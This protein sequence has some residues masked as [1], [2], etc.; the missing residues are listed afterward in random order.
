MVKLHPVAAMTPARLQAEPDL[1]AALS[2]T[3]ADMIDLWKRM[4]AIFPGTVLDKEDDPE[5]FFKAKTGENH[6]ITLNQTKEYETK[7]K[8]RLTA[9][10]QSHP[11]LYEKL[12]MAQLPPP[13]EAKKDVSDILY[14]VVK[15]LKDSDLLPAVA[16]QLDTY[17]AFS[18]FKTLLS[19]LE[20]EQVAEF[21]DY[22]KDLMKL[23]RDKAQMRKVAAGQ[24][25][26]VNAAEAEE[27]AKSGFTD[28]T[29]T[30]EDTTK[31]H[32]K[33]VLS[34]AGM[35]LGFYEVEDIIADMKKAGESVDV[36]HALIRGLRRGIAIYTNEVGFSCYRRQV[37]MLAQKG[38][39]AVVFSDEAIA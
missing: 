21:P 19:R 13:L 8:A 6:R 29:L 18:M 31:P 37:Q 2:M 36:N 28:D 11:E 33:Y 15:Q 24:A 20:S 3:P 10:S 25:S 1:I 4:K 5:N 26:R 17:G 35:R 27:D 23:A 30:Q 14:G 16:F 34:P 32:D 22:R 38:R 9:L 7:L 12:R 39:L